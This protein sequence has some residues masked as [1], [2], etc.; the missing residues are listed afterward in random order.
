MCRMIV[1]T[2]VFRPSLLVCALRVMA[3][4]TNADHP[5]ERRAKGKEHRHEDGWG[6]VWLQDGALERRRRAQSCLEDPALGEIG[7]LLTPLLVLHARRASR[8]EPSVENTHPFLVE[9]GGC[10]W[11]LVHNGS[12]DDLGPLARLPGVPFRGD[13]DSERLLHHLLARFEPE[14][15]EDSLREAL[16]AIGRYTALN[17]ILVTHDRFYAIAWPHPRTTRRRYFTLWQGE[18]PGLLVVS[19]EPVAGLGCESWAPI[20][21]SAAGGTR[22]V[23]REIPILPAGAP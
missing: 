15:A 16:E 2:G 14:R 11:A 4:N 6:A 8:G 9:L 1:A 3:S 23:V 10:P 7:S 18:G 21:T 12:V 13:T 17:S 5:H 19:S 20:G 22:H